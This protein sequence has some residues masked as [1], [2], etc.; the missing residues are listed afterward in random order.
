MKFLFLCN[1]L[2]P[3]FPTFT[4]VNDFLY[5]FEGFFASNNVSLMDFS[6]VYCYTGTT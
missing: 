6:V 5:Y 1:H 2:Q 4:S 3:V